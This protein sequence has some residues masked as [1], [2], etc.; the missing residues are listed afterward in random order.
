MNA[1][2]LPARAEAGS[3]LV[4]PAL[5]VSG[6][7]K[8]FAGAEVLKGVDFTLAPGQSTALIGANGSGWIR[9]KLI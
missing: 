6:L 8:A 4:E 2:V 7:T 5:A 3:T 9:R 1:P